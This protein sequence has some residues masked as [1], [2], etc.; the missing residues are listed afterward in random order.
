MDKDSRRRQRQDNVIS[1]LNVAIDGL[2]LTKEVLSITPAKAVCGSVGF[3][4]TVIRVCFPRVRV[5][6]C[7]L[8]SKLTHRIQC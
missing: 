5:D 7:G 1:S 3:V 4:L 6:R 8:N 2:N